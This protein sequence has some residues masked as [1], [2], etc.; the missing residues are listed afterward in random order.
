MSPFGAVDSS[1]D[2]LV[3]EDPERK[4]VRTVRVGTFFPPRD[5]TIDIAAFANGKT[6]RFDR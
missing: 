5:P 2:F 1:V 3:V 4:G 6:D